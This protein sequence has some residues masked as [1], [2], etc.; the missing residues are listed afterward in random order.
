VGPKKLRRRLSRGR[1]LRA[2]PKRVAQ[3]RIS[4][5]PLSK[6][7]KRSRQNRVAIVDIG[8]NSIRLVVFDRISRAPLLLFNE[9]VLCGL[10]RGL[11]E[12]GRLNEEGVESALMNLTRF[13]RLAKAMG[14]RRLDLL[15]TAAVRDAS[16]G[17]Q[18][19]A[20][21]RR[22][23][24]VPVRIISGAEEAKYSALG[25][26][27]GIGDADG[28]MGDLGGGSVE[29][30]GLDHGRLGPH[31]TLPLGP[32]RVGEAALADREQARELIDGHLQ[33]VPWLGDL[34][35]RN[36][37][38]VG[39][40]WRSLARIHMDQT[41]HP[42]HIIQ[43][44]RID[45]H[46]AEDLLRVMSRLG[47]RSLAAI[48]GLPRRRVDTLP[49]AALLLER[50]LRIAR[51]EA[52]IFSA[53]GLR[54]GYLFH[55]LSPAQ[56]KLDPL[57]AA[58]SELA[59]RDGRFGLMGDLLTQWTAPLFEGETPE[60]HRL[61]QAVCR[62]S[63]IAWRDHPDYRAEQSF[64][65]ILRLPIGGID[66]E[67]RVFAATSVA[68]R[69]AGTMEPVIH[70]PAL[71]MMGEAATTRALSLGL[72]LRLAY[73]LSGATPKLLV[74][75]SLRLTAGRLTLVLPRNGSIMY[76]EAVGRRLDA[77]GRA[78]HRSVVTSTAGRRR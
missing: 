32:L 67:Q 40:A 37:Y 18:F 45:R 46:Q 36:F 74:Q 24:G 35:G 9:K 43:H 57:L 68:V 50:L 8:S 10:G 4:G 69:Y 76:G 63:D 22:R 54:E 15:A 38:P 27:S 71:R 72:A 12:T 65:R 1:S 61:R 75:S 2:E 53:F 5:A 49:F 56:R 13:V 66:H 64:D 77:L 7:R 55:Q 26:V 34:R 11:D 48:S 23:C 33:T 30:V 29:L 73:S 47:R 41:G 58:A 39:G 51:P 20:A 31:V 70:E 19:A 60:Q 28:I 62:L 78:L 44:Y 25:V 17:P 16:N 42:L 14:A 52:I 6:S 21:V 59:D 3:T